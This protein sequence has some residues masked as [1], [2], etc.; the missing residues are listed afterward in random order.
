[1]ISN[2]QEQGPELTLDSLTAAMKQIEDMYLAHVPKQIVEAWGREVALKLAKSAEGNPIGSTRVLLPPGY[3]QSGE[4]FLI[5][6][7]K[8]IHIMGSVYGATPIPVV[9]GGVRESL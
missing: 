6:G 5:Q 3:A 7:D 1:M 4:C 8:L 9:F 2:S